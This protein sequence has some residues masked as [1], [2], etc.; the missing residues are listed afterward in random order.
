MIFTEMNVITRNSG[1]PISGD[2][3]RA[4]GYR[5]SGGKVG[6]NEVYI[7]EKVYDKYQE[8]MKKGSRLLR[9]MQVTKAD[10]IAN[11]LAQKLGVKTSILWHY[12]A[13]KDPIYYHFAQN[14]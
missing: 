14:K 2:V 8:K 7:E 5:Q 12:D 1:L 9:D 13:K 11:S 3:L 4:H 6:Y 10:K